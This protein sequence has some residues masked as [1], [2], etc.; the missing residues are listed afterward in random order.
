MHVECALQI[1]WAAKV[2]R[3]L[4]SEQT[5]NQWPY[6]P[7][8]GSLEVPSLNRYPECSSITFRGDLHYSR[9]GEF[10]GE[11]ILQKY[12]RARILGPAHP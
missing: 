11:G 4:I 12:Q 1:F 8:S 2:L 3:L 5:R 6:K 7:Y 9:G 10:T